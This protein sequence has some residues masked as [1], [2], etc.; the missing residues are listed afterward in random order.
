M[1]SK[2]NIS[3]LV[4][5]FSLSCKCLA[6][7]KDS[8]ALRKT[9]IGVVVGFSLSPVLTIHEQSFPYRPFNNQGMIDETN[10]YRNGLIITKL[11]YTFYEVLISTKQ[12][13][14]QILGFSYSFKS[15]HSDPGPLAGYGD[16]KQ[17]TL[18][19][20]YEYDWLIIKSKS[21][22]SEKWASPFL[23][24]R[25][26]YSIKHLDY[27]LHTDDVNNRINE[28]SLI[29]DASIIGFQPVIGF[30]VIRKHFFFSAAT[31]INGYAFISGKYKYGHMYSEFWNPSSNVFEA[32]E[33]SYSKSL[34]GAPHLISE[35]NVKIGYKF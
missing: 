5:L 20:Y 15:L 12:F 19:F 14:Q 9:K 13:D 30:K 11:T 4:I 21:D 18:N 10:M 3:F 29:D 24:F 2:R 23:G 22:Y 31:C 8:L 1:K 17:K 32:K 35:F 34:F 27:F 25:T 16:T 33:G 28:T 7:Q 6:E 26:I